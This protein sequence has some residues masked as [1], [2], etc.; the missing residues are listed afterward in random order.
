MSVALDV[1]IPF[2][3]LQAQY[4]PIQDEI[5][6]AIEEVLRSA[7]FIGGKYVEGFEEE[8]ASYVGSRFALGVAS[9]TAALELALRAVGIHPGDEV[10]V[11]TNTFFATAEAVSNIGARPVFADVDAQTFHLDICSVERTLTTRTR[12][13]IPVHLYGRVMDITELETLAAAHN[14]AIIED[15]AQAHGAQRNGVK[16][17]GSGRITCFS[18][19]PGKNLGAYGDAGLI[20]TDDFKLAEKIRLLRDHGSPAKYQHTV[21]GTNSRLDA[22]QAS[23][24]SVKLRHLDSWN[25]KRRENA[26]RYQCLLKGSA[27]S[28]PQIPQDG[29]HVFHLF[30]VRTPERDQVRAFLASKGIDTAVHYPVPLH[31]T[32]A[33]QALGYPGRGT[34][35]VAEMLANQILSLPMYPELTEAQIA[36]TTEA[37]LQRV[38][39]G[40]HC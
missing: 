37:L 24:L 2:V 7:Q 22:I 28:L 30:V 23:V 16:V 32:A 13:V 14:L 18:C 11:P 19:Y 35:P 31:L 33:Y 5:R 27:V 3:D 26:F 12:A 20:T 29:E 1:R 40:T 36:R 6:S 38:L 9:G 4:T 17:G 21:V 15:A 39:E 10:I 34:L 25:A 8:F